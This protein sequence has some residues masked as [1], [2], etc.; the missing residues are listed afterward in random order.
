MADGV[1]QW[2]R[3]AFE[4]NPSLRAW[5]WDDLVPGWRGMAHVQRSRRLA[6][7]LAKRKWPKFKAKFQAE[8]LRSELQK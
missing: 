6:L 7:E 1:N 8:R 4:Q 5:A 2:W 3:E